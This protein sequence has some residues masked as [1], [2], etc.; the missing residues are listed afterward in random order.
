MFFKNL[1]LYS[2]PKNWDMAA[3]HLANQLSQQKFAPCLDGNIQS[4][5]WVAPRKNGDLVHVIGK[6]MLLEFRVAKKLLPASIVNQVT[7][8][9][10]EHIEEQQGFVPGRKQMRD[11]KEQVT[12]E[13]LPRA[14][15]LE[16]STLVWIDPVSGWL[17]V[18]TVSPSKADEVLK[19]LLKSVDKLPVESLH[20]VKSPVT[21]M[22][23]WLVANEAPAGFTIDQ[24]TE[25][26]ATGEGNASVRY[27]RHTLEVDD[28]RRHIA[29]GKQCM[30]LALTWNDRISF[31]LTDGLAIKRVQPLDVMKQV[32]AT[33]SNDDERFDSDFT[34]MAGE[35]GKML[36]DLVAALGGQV[37]P[38]QLV[39]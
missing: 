19:L 23:G 33:C 28:V 7:K 32:D 15:T 11:I 16:R 9:K 25:L 13:L 4:L 18:D 36:T 20:V 1:Q 30:H 39:Q 2:L 10:T 3:S 5:G 26:R 17:V 14:F 8:V 22:T 12:D 29:G 31:V 38:G 6:Q 21:S 35:L 34:L 27:V 24:D 37:T